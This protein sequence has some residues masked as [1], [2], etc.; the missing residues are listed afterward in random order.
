MMSTTLI[1]WFTNIII[2]DNNY[3][4]RIRA[5]LLCFV[6][7]CFVAL[8]CLLLCCFALLLCFVALLCLLLCC[9]ALLLCFVAL[10]CLGCRGN[11]GYNCPRTRAK[12]EGKDCYSHNFQGNCTITIIK[13]TLLVSAILVS[14]RQLGTALLLLFHLAVQRGVIA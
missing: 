10:L 6:L 4:M 1:T 3:A 13:F 2:M 11:Y 7:L 12:P 14:Y 9:F 8:L 5:S